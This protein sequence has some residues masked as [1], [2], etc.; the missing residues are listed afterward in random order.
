MDLLNR[1]LQMSFT[2]T[3]PHTLIMNVEKQ[4]PISTL[5]AYWATFSIFPSM[6]LYND[7]LYTDSFFN[8]DWRWS[9]TG[10]FA[11]QKPDNICRIKKAKPIPESTRMEFSC[12]AGF[13][14]A[15]K[16]G[17]KVARE[18]NTHHKQL[19]PR[20][21]T[22]TVV[23]SVG[24]LQKYGAWHCHAKFLFCYG[25]LIFIIFYLKINKIS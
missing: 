4:L 10:A 3:G 9:T 1:K 23:N 6:S 8:L 17:A 15:L 2:S 11:F 20:G 22:S 12:T 21:S 13:C 24:I 16:Q 25:K 18:Q 5:C 19:Q 14:I 7:H